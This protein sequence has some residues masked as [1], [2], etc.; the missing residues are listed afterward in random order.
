[1]APGAR[2]RNH[3]SAP[4]PPP[5]KTTADVKV[6]AF[7]DPDDST[8]DTDSN[9]SSSPEDLTPELEDIPEFP[10][11]FLFD[12]GDIRISV[13]HNKRV[14]EGR[15]SSHSL[16]NVSPVWKSKLLPS[17]DE[18]NELRHSVK[19]IDCTEDNSEALL[20]LLNICHSKFAKVPS[21]LETAKL[22]HVATL[23]RKYD[24]IDAI[25]PWLTAKMWLA[26]EAKESTGVDWK[27]WIR[28][29]DCLGLQAIFEK[30]VKHGA[31]YE[32]NEESINS[33]TSLSAGIKGKQH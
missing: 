30:L 14:V 32:K 24:C 15:V 3:E 7:S 18:D 11:E 20:I 29:A 12:T 2:G 10:N 23:C 19:Q 25:Q 16:S 27:I 17:M 9:Y 4:V 28:I 13:T 21:N 1:M 8:A 22:F 6:E 26:K 33:L 31:V 5:N